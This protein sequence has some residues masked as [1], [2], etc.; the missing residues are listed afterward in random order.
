[1]ATE[2]RFSTAFGAYVC[3]GDTISC[4]V[5]GL[6]ITATIIHDE[7]SGPPWEE[8]DMHG[9]VSEWTSRLKRPGERVLCSDKSSNR[10]Y[11]YAGAIKRAKSEGWDTEPYGTGTKGERAV[12]AV[13]ESLDVLKAWC[14]NKWHWCGVVLSVSKN[15]VVLQSNAAAIWSVDCNYPGSDNSF[16]TEAANALLDEAIAAGKETLKSLCE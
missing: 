16:L 6:E 8:T 9:E 12:R 13:E 1:M 10:F 15:S 2:N 3:C 4:N 7:D 5:D 11:D 14:E